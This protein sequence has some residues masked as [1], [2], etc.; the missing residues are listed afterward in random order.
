MPFRL[1][2]DAREWFKHIEPDLGL[3]FDMYYFCLIAGLA[4]GTKRDTPADQT[5]ELVDNFPQKYAAKSRLIIGLFL[6][7]EIER[8]GIDFSSRDLVYKQIHD[9]VDINTAHMLSDVGMREMN[10]LSY[11]GLEVLMEYFEERPASIETFLPEFQEH[12]ERLVLSS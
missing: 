2:K 11:G 6:A 9:L 7:K 4:T 8:M 1:R 3:D 10:R 12:I 5:T